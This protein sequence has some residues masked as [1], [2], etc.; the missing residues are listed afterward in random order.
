[1]VERWT[2]ACVWSK[3]RT[4]NKQINLNDDLCERI[5]KLPSKRTSYPCAHLVGLSNLSVFFLHDWTSD[6]RDDFGA[7]MEDYDGSP[8]NRSKKDMD[9]PFLVWNILHRSSSYWLED[10]RVKQAHIEV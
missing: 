4:W 1:M 9:N 2:V 10:F 3:T 6:F 5:G 8:F 7:L